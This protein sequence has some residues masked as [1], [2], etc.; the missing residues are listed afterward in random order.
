MIEELMRLIELQNIELEVSRIHA[1]RKNLP[2]QMKTL[3]EEFEL[4]CK[5]V[6]AQRE[7]VENARKRRREKDAQLQ[8][9]QDALKRTREKLFEVKNNKEYQSMLKEIEAFES[10]NSKIEDEVLVLLDEIERLETA[11]K[12]AEEELNGRRRLFEEGK[13]KIEDE[14]NSL[15]G[16][17]EA[18][19]RKGEEAKEKIPTE[20]IRRYQK[21]KASGRSVAVV[22]AWKEICSGCHMA[23][24]PQMYNELQ[25]ATYLMICPN[26]D[27]IIYWENRNEGNEKTPAARARREEMPDEMQDDD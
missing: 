22:S 9:G 11:L 8:T 12:V 21:I 20:F 5:T 16:E 6:E 4:L 15:E 18:C 24:P 1:R 17:Q 3:E 2:V 13:K 26:C 7:Q 19:L 25:K 27:R 14:M 10:K 23:L